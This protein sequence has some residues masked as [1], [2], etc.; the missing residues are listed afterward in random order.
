M[1]SFVEKSFLEGKF[2]REVNEILI[3]LIPRLTYQ[4]WPHSFDRYCCVM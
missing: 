3:T 4:N 2:S 1:F